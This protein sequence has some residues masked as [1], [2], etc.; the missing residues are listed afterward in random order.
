MP[1]NEAD[2]DLRPTAAAQVALIKQGFGDDILV[3]THGDRV[4]FM[5]HKNTLLVRDE[6]VDRVVDIIT[7]PVIDVRSAEGEGSEQRAP[8]E[9]PPPRGVINGLSLLLLDGTRFP[10]DVLGAIREIEDDGRVPSG[11]FTPNHILYE[12]NGVHAPGGQCPATEPEEVPDGAA[13]DPPVCPG[14][15]GKGVLVYVADGG[16]LADANSHQWL[17]GVTGDEDPLQGQPGGPALIPS[18]AG[19]GTFVAGLVRC[20]APAS[21]VFVAR[22]FEV[23]GAL[24][25]AE[26]ILKVQDALQYGPDVI[27]FSAGGTTRGDHHLLTFEYLFREFRYVKGVAFVAAA[28]N[29][30]ER[31]PF[32]PAAFPETVSV[33]A[34]GANWRSRAYF[35]NYGHWVDVYAPGEGLVNAFARGEF[36]CE[37]PPH[38]DEVREFYGMAKWSGTSFSTP[39]VAGLIAARMSRTGENGRRAA[40]ALLAKARAQT[41]P[42]L[43]AVLYPCLDDNDPPAAH[44]D[45]RHGVCRH[46]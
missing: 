30:N 34:L 24:S 2:H 9:M 37:E 12:V 8:V 20:M 44:R 18:Y 40:E 15:D 26:L 46:C 1:S 10:R 41:I 4:D 36:T 11:A 38:E 35:S 17:K 14:H 39:V 23:A 16:L 43:G 45:H 13:P 3:V 42:G 33:G 32:W 29:R 21:D 27:S 7:E 28:G 5:C 19:H 25:E 31:R 6:Y 22:L